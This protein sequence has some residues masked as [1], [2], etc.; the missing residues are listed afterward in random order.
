MMRGK[1]MY[2]DNEGKLGFRDLRLNN[3]AYGRPT[4]DYAEAGIGL[5]KDNWWKVVA[6]DGSYCPLNP[7]IHT[8]TEHSDDTITVQPSIVTDTWHGWLIKGMWFHYQ[9][10]RPLGL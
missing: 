9:E 3:G 5:E 2:P 1:R 10:P 7:A 6:P 8:V 4:L